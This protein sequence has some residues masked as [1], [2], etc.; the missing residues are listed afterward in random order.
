MIFWGAPDEV[1]VQWLS[2]ILLPLDE[3]KHYFSA[4][5]NCQYIEENN[6]ADSG[7]LNHYLQETNHGQQEM[8]KE[9]GEGDNKH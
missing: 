3:S 5:M 9:A 7:N 1:L 2:I 6:H 4:F 8:S